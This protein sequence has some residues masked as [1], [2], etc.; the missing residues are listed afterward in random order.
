MQK[1]YIFGEIFFLNLGSANPFGGKHWE[2][3]V[4]NWGTNF[5]CSEHFGPS[6][7][8]ISKC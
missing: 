1:T 2:F 5:C 8:L 4:V 7:M 3:L 6:K